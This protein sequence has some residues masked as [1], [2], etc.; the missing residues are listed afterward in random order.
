MKH[1]LEALL[2]NN[3]HSLYLL[4]VLVFSSQIA[5]SQNP[6]MPPTAFIPDEEPHVL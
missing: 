3:N 1:Y 2:Q 6:F 5:F 4:C